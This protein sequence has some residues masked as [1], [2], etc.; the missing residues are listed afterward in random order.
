MPSLCL[1]HT[2]TY[3]HTHRIGCLFIFDHW[4]VH[5]FNSVCFLSMITLRTNSS[6]GNWRKMKNTNK[7]Q[8]KKNTGWE[9]CSFK[10]KETFIYLVISKIATD[11]SV[12][13]ADQQSRINS[14]VLTWSVCAVKTL[15]S[16]SRELQFQ[17]DSFWTLAVH[18]G[19]SLYFNV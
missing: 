2:H 16:R 10:N 8:T 17:P 14:V 19:G 1:C 6:F 12:F 15:P 11:S 13:G 5:L 4:F 9:N 3:T 18:R 7:R